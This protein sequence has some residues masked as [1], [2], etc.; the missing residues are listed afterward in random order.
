MR[1]KLRKPR[2]EALHN[3]LAAKRGGAHEEK[4]GKRIKRARQK[5]QF[6]KL[7]KEIQ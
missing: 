6:R 5:Q 3:L 2:N 1:S 4:E 7:L